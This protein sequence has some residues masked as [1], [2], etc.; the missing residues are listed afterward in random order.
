MSEQTTATTGDSTAATSAPSTQTADSFDVESWFKDDSTT[1]APAPTYLGSDGKPV[2]PQQATSETAEAPTEAPSSSE[3][4]ARGPDGKFVKREGAEPVADA[5]PA[6]AEAPKADARPFQYRAAG[7]TKAWDGVH[8]QPD[9]TVIVPADK[10]GDLRAALNARVIA[11]GHLTPI[12]ERHKQENQR[13]SSEVQRLAQ[14]RTVESQQAQA[15]VSQF[16]RVL[17]P[18]MDEGQAI[19]AFFAL[20]SQ[21]PVLLAEAKAQYYQQQLQQPRAP[22]APQPETARAEP[23]APPVPSADQAWAT[24]QEYVEQAKLDPQFRDVGGEDWKQLVTALER[25][26]YAFLRPATDEEAQ[27]PGEVVFDV[28]ALHAHLQATTSRSRE[29]RETAARQAKLA[30]EN[31]RRTQPSVHAPP[32]VG[33]GKAPG[34]AAPKLETGEDVDAWLD[35][36]TRA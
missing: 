1:A 9:G 34:A 26:P 3:G 24:T 5:E 12:I 14:S 11:E 36:L 16:G 7:E 22:Q 28:D 2:P 25:T 33:S 27:Y 29:A 8:E 6:A 19:E 20:R 32:T 21:W 18:N 13:L 15:L 35:D 31:A 17:D 10:V 23:P 30:A 4:P